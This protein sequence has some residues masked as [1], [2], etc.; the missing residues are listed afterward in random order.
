L[1]TEHLFA[2][3]IEHMFGSFDIRRAASLAAAA[4]CALALAMSYAAPSSSGAA[5]GHYRRHVVSAG[6]TLWAI[7]ERAYPSADPRDAVYRIEQANDLH[8]ADISA[9]QVLVLP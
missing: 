8:G 9:G 5:P 1:T 6:E 7:A 2:T 3:L 4:A